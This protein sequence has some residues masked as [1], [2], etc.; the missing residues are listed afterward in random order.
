M[1]LRETKL[2]GLYVVDMEPLYDERGCF[3]RAFDRDLWREKGL[4]SDFVQQSISFTRRRGTIRGMHYQSPPWEEDKLVRV[5]RGAVFDVALDLRASSPGF[6]C[7]H[8]IELT[9]ENRLALYIPKGFA[10]GFQT[11]EDDTEILY[12][13][14]VAY[15]PESACGVRWNDPAFGIVW[16]DMHHAV[17]CA[18]DNAYD[19]FNNTKMR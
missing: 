3:A 15:H 2:D 12:Q 11:L 13:M 10:H 6:C 5:T 16:P 14:T 18:R 17:L 8:G 9:A 19:D 4:N 7:W 1:V